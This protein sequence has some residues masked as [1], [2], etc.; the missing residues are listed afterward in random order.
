MEAGRGCG[1]VGV[2]LVVLV[3]FSVTAAL[4]TLQI[5]KKID[6]KCFFFSLGNIFSLRSFE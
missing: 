5:K 6:Y 2:C 4:L 3:V 1:V